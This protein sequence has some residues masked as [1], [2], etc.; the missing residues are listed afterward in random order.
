MDQAERTS[1]AKEIVTATTIEGFTV[2]QVVRG[3]VAKELYHNLDTEIVPSLKVW[4]KRYLGKNVP[5]GCYNSRFCEFSTR[6]QS[7]G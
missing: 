7:T 2:R 4:L 5:G 6:I 3:T 1:E